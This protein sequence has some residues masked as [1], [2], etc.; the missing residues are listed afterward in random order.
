MHT[1][2]TGKLKAQHPYPL[3]LTNS[4]VFQNSYMDSG[5]NYSEIWKKITEEKRHYIPT[6]WFEFVFFFN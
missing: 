6:P 4:L 3:F 1:C 2:T 5:V